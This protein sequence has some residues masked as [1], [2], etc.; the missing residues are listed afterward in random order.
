M[1]E[2]CL[3][4]NVNSADVEKPW[5]NLSWIQGSKPGRAVSEWVSKFGL[6]DV[7]QTRGPSLRF[8]SHKQPQGNCPPIWTSN[9]PRRVFYSVATRW[10]SWMLFPTEDMYLGGPVFP[11]SGLCSAALSA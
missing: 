1:T 10:G 5:S 9:C 7:S 2:N 8:W 6:R 4:P 3:A 11:E